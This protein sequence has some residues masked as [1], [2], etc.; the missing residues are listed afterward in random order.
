MNSKQFYE[1]PVSLLESANAGHK[2]RIWVSAHS[3]DQR[4][5]H[6]SENFYTRNYLYEALI[7]ANATVLSE[8]TVGQS[9]GRN[10]F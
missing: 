4:P 6:D 3:L 5:Q 8:I 9:P 10:C 1:Y 7:G 2:T